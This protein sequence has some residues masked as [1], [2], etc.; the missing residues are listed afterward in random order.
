MCGWLREYEQLTNGRGR[1]FLRRESPFRQKPAPRE[2]SRPTS[3]VLRPSPFGDRTRISERKQYDEGLANPFAVERAAV[4][5][6]EMRV[7]DRNRLWD[8]TGHR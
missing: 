1:R 3:C 8:S 6:E 7:R 5:G 2:R 4:G